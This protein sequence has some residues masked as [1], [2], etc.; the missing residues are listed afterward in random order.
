ME[1]FDINNSPFE[2]SEIREF[3]NDKYRD[4]VKKEI[5]DRV[6]V[7]DYS[8]ASH[9]NG[10]ELECYD[11]EELDN[12]MYFIVIEVNQKAELKTKFAV[13]NQDI[14]IV[15]PR[16]NKQYRIMSGHTKLFLIKKCH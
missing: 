15:N 7:L 9:L 6:T 8:S 2:L 16:N 5:A 3:F 1:E 4:K 13:Y 14:V 12:D 11:F 10:V